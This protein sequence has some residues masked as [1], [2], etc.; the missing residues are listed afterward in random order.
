M[1]YVFNGECN[2][3]IKQAFIDAYKPAPTYHADTWYKY[4]DDTEWRT[5]SITGTISGN[6]SAG[7]MTE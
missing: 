1:T 6:L 4:A 3:S 2:I 5:V 7:I